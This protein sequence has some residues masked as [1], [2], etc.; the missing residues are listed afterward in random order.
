M[1]Q[2]PGTNA[3]AAKAAFAF[4]AGSSEFAGLAGPPAAWPTANLLPGV[5]PVR[6]LIGATSDTAVA[7]TGPR[8]SARGSASPSSIAPTRGQPAVWKVAAR[9][10]RLVTSWGGVRA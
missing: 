4:G 9:T 5:A 8:T 6:Q 3:I 7:V 10:Y 2:Q 1:E